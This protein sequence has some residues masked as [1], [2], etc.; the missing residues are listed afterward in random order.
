MR[1]VDVQVWRVVNSWFLGGIDGWMRWDE[2]G[3]LMEEGKEEE[4]V[5]WEGKR[6]GR[7]KGVMY[8]WSRSGLVSQLFK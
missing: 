1:G 2:A 8:I 7:K 5:R 3:G 4:E 6:E